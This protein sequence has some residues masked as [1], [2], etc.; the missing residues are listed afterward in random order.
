M[1][2]ILEY[3]WP[4]YSQ[5]PCLNI[6]CQFLLVSGSFSSSFRIGAAS[7]AAACHLPSRLVQSSVTTEILASNCESSRLVN[8]TVITH[9]HPTMIFV[10]V[11][12]G[13]RT[14]ART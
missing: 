13:A 7:L 8:V 6:C 12:V 10:L 14:K 3:I 9:V 4:A 5:R 2:V 11:V 1:D